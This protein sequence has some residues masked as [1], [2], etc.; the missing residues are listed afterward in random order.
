VCV[1][2]WR[3][4]SPGSGSGPLAGS[5]EC[6]DEPSG[7]GPH[8]VSLVS[9]FRHLAVFHPCHYKK[10]HTVHLVHRFKPFALSEPQFAPVFQT[11]QPSMP[12]Q[13][14]NQELFLVNSNFC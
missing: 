7:S 5:R 1:C 2:V 11:L 9:K 6:G 14:N 12:L 4:D 3:E 10:P 13:I 8:I